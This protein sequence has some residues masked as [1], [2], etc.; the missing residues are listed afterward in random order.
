MSILKLL[1][2]L[3][4]SPILYIHGVHFPSKG[5]LCSAFSFDC[6]GI[7]GITLGCYQPSAFPP[8]TTRH[9]VHNSPT[10]KTWNLRNVF[11]LPLSMVEAATLQSLMPREAPC[12]SCIVI[13]GVSDSSPITQATYAA[14]TTLDRTKSVSTVTITAIPQVATVTNCIMEDTNNARHLIRREAP[15]EGCIVID[16]LTYSSPIVQATS[17]PCTTFIATVTVTVNPSTATVT[18]ETLSC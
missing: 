2:S 17:T 11:L 18:T 3:V 10:R 12:N 13:D 15:C 4:L 8:R 5:D 1:T 6:A 14:A 9:L 7:V 16:S